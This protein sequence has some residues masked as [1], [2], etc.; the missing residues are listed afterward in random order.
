MQRPIFTFHTPSTKAHSVSTMP[1]EAPLLDRYM[2]HPFALIVGKYK[3]V[4]TIASEHICFFQRCK[5][6]SLSLLITRSHCGVVII[7]Q[8]WDEAGVNLGYAWIWSTFSWVLNSPCN[9]MVY[10]KKGYRV[11]CAVSIS[12]WDDSTCSS[13]C[14]EPFHLRGEG[15]FCVSSVQSEWQAVQCCPLIMLYLYR[16]DCREALSHRD[17]TI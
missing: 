11:E 9:V 6:L 1:A 15:T 17:F 14:A 16:T 4:W 5:C 7:S 12:L 8:D 2:F 3:R 10:E 13:L